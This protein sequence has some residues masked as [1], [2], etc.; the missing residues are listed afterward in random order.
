MEIPEDEPGVVYWI[1][2]ND[3]EDTMVEVCRALKDIGINVT[4]SIIRSFSPERYD[5][6][7][8]RT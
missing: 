3:I 8:K 7:F 6:K 5:F 4:V 2:D 1:Y